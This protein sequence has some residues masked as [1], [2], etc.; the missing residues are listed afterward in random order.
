MNKNKKIQIALIIFGSLL[1][2]S[3]Y[4]FYPKISEKKI[5]KNELNIKEPL[6]ITTEQSNV[7]ENVSY[8]GFY[9][10]INPFT[11]NSD[12]AYILEEEPEIV[13]MKEMHVTLY[14]N[15]GRIIVITS[16]EGVYNKVSYN[17]FFKNNVKAT[18]GETELLSDNLD[19]LANEDYASVYNNVVLSSNKG[20]M[21]AD[22]V[23]YNFET[24]LYDITMFDDKPVKIKLIK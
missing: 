21:V 19:L 22:K 6:K 5:L 20:T 8:E 10:V 24:E 17:C 11:I 15:D 14:M 18:D 1:I 13:Y 23:D 3:T 4:F 12:N 16:D 7:F 2:F 9:N